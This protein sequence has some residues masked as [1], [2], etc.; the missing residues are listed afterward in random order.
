MI[1]GTRTRTRHTQAQTPRFSDS[2][3]AQ[4]GDAGRVYRKELRRI[5][6]DQ[7][8]NAP[9]RVRLYHVGENSFMA[10]LDGTKATFAGNPLEW[11]KS[12]SSV[13]ELREQLY[14]QKTTNEVDALTATLES[15]FARLKL[16]L[17]PVVKASDIGRPRVDVEATDPEF[18]L[19]ELPSGEYYA[20]IGENLAEFLPLLPDGATLEDYQVA[21]RY[22]NA[23]YED[24]HS[25][26]YRDS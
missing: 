23:G 21:V 1:R 26:G 18:A 5:G 6:F 8:K 7:D 25:A 2:L 15:E 14:A 13:E 10:E 20:S 3:P 9:Y 17:R 24:G 11:L 16:P 4:T 22:Y 12:L 19:G